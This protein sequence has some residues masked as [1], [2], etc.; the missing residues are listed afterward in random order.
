LTE[1]QHLMERFGLIT[2]DDLASLLGVTVK[3]LKNRPR[4]DLPA[5]VKAGRK[6]LFKA[7]AVEDYLKARTVTAA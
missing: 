3:T 2:E 4:R 1:P 7:A 6:R 5:F